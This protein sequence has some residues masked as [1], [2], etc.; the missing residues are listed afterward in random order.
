MS[1]G[2]ESLVNVDDLKKLGVLS[3]SITG[4]LAKIL[5]PQ[6]IA[7]YSKNANQKEL[8]Q[9]LC[10]VFAVKDDFG[11]VREVWQDFYK[12]QFNFDVDFSRVVIP[13]CPGIN[14]RLLFI[15]K[16]ITMSKAFARCGE[17]FKTWKYAD[18]L[19]TAIPKH[20]RLAQQHYAVWVQIGAEPDQ[21]YLGKSTREADPDMK[22]G[23]TVLER[24]IFELKYF[25]ETGNHLDVKG[26][27]FCSGSRDSVG[28]VPSAVW[29]GDEFR[30][31]W[32]YLGSSYSDCGIRSA[33]SL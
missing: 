22:I 27:T 23:I 8:T 14:W 9:R 18:N 5:S 2:T 32:Y 30:V 26:V 19:E 3:G 29:S 31:S 13:E 15:A 21:E 17:L 10:E 12:A 28:D 7:Y 11:D 20:A 33:V 16:G 25:L 4:C 24:I 6:M 1:N